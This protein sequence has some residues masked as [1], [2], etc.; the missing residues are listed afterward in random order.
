MFKFIKTIFFFLVITVM[1]SCTIFVS[2]YLS[3]VFSHPFLSRE[4][5]IAQTEKDILS[6]INFVRE[7]NDTV[8]LLY[9]RHNN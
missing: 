1:V 4:K 2:T 3:N 7:H 9:D 5:N 6:W 8:R